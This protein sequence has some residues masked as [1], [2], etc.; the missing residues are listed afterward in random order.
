MEAAR[1]AG[2]RWIT[3]TPI[4]LRN[5]VKQIRVGPKGML[6]AVLN[7]ASSQDYGKT[8]EPTMA[9]AVDVLKKGQ[10]QRRQREGEGGGVLHSKPPSPF[11]HYFRSFVR[12][13]SLGHLGCRR[14]RERQSERILKDVVAAAA[15][16][17]SVPLSIPSTSVSCVLS[18]GGRPAILVVSPVLPSSVNEGGVK[19]GAHTSRRGEVLVAEGQRRRGCLT[20][21][22]AGSAAALS[23]GRGGVA[24]GGDVCAGERGE[25]VAGPPAA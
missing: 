6:L 10:R 23:P 21:G 17:S 16:R 25:I 24:A 2:C 14:Q 22:A 12:S 19:S 20:L 13:E 5:V 15:V 9:L 18:F 3:N 7:F 1:G 11:V 8:V 4:T